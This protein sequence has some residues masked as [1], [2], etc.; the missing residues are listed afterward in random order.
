MQESGRLMVLDRTLKAIRDLSD[1]DMMLE[2][3]AELPFEHEPD[4]ELLKTLSPQQQNDCWR[5][6]LLVHAVTDRKLVPRTFQLEAAMPTLR[7]E[8]SVVIAGTG[9][10]KTLIAAIP[11]LLHPEAISFIV[12]PLKRLQSAQ[13]NDYAR[14]GVRAIAI[15]GDTPRDDALWKNIREGMYSLLIISP[16]QLFMHDGHL[17]RMAHLLSD[18]RFVSL[19][20]RVHVDEAHTIYT[21]GISKH[22]EPAY[23]PA[24]GQIGNLRVLLQK[25]TPF[26]LLSAS[27][28]DHT[29]RIVKE[30]TLM[31]QQCFTV[32]TSTNRPNITYATVPLVGGAS[33]LSNLDFLVPENYTESMGQIKKT[34]VFHDSRPQS[35]DVSSYLDARL[36]KELRDSGI[37]MH[38]HSGMSP[39]YLNKLFADFASPTGRCRILCATSGAS[40][41]SVIT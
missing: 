15:N 13:V 28:T 24:W 37:V 31:H 9:S 21:A 38:Y 20:K 40:T 11:C 12:S 34:V 19:V 4:E 7:N 17:P 3:L 18:Q 36:S 14:L 32:R 1:T 10:G 2:A 25:G 29:L 27:L 41:V 22:G 16:E 39:T 23:R 26:Q 8:D 33:N 6:C 5:A 35:S 30:K